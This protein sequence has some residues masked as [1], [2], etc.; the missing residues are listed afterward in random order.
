MIELSLADKAKHCVA[1]QLRKTCNQVIIDS[2]KVSVKLIVCSDWPTPDDDI[3]GEPGHGQAGQFLNSM[4]ARAGLNR[5]V[6]YLT[7]VIKCK[8]SYGNKPTDVHINICKGWLWKEIL[9]YRPNIVLALGKLPTRLLLKLKKSFKLGDYIGKL[10]DVSYM[11]TK[12]GSWYGIDYLLNQG[13]TTEKKT[14]DYFKSI[15]E[16]LNA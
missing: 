16:T 13:R 4:L 15:K 1:C 2:P 9:E 6:V 14:I 12:V 8:P 10:Y 11:N 3:I 5:E 7:N